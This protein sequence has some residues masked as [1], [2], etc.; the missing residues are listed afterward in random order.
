MVFLLLCIF[1]I[2]STPFSSVKA[3]E[4]F[5][6]IVDSNTPFYTS[7][8][9][10]EPLF[11]LPYTYYVKVL[12]NDNAFVH[13]ECRIDDLSPAIDGYVPKGL[14]FS[15]ELTVVKPYVNVKIKTLSTAILFEESTLTTPLQ[16]V[17]ADRELTYFG[18]YVNK[19]GINLFYVSYNNRLGYI[20]ESDVYPFAIENHPNELTFITPEEPSIENPNATITPSNTEKDLLS[21]KII[22]I[23]CLVLGGVVALIF[24]FKAKPNRYSSCTVYDENEFE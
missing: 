16:Y 2:F 18:C 19:G 15:D 7:I 4:K 5:L 9:D 12:S 13:V 22:I 11:Y 23:S 3:D 6:R 17:F 21:I 8:T 1:Q 10:T 20:K 24:A 14:L